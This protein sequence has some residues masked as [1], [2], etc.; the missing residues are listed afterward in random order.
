MKCI[1]KLILMMI[2]VIFLVGCSTSGMN[3]K[4]VSK[5]A[6]ERNTITKVQND[7]NVI[8]D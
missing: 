3:D 6:I 4:N 2:P 8:I 7:V 1:K 5:E